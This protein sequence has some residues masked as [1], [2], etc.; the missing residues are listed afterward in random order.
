MSPPER[1]AKWN[2]K[3]VI[4]LIAGACAQAGFEVG[5]KAGLAAAPASKVRNMR[6]SLSIGRLQVVRPEQLIP[7]CSDRSPTNVDKWW[8]DLSRHS[9]TECRRR[10]TRTP[11]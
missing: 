8:P 4:R 2:A 7:V 11:L 9:A 6:R 1:P 5:L 3:A 10:T